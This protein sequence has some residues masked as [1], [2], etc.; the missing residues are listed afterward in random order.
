M[1]A[2]SLAWNVAGVELEGIH[3]TQIRRTGKGCLSYLVASGRDALVIDASLPPEIYLALSERRGARIRYVLDTHIHA[4]HLSR[5]RILAEKA[6]AE[7]LLP[8]QDR[9]SFP[10]RPIGSGEEIRFGQA[11]LESIRT[12]GHTLESTCYFIN[13]QAL[14][15]GDT[16]FTA[17]VGRPDLHA[18]SDEALE[19]ARLLYASLKQLLALGRDV[20]VFP[21]HTG[22]PVPFDSK[23][24]SAHISEITPR[25]Q[26]WLSSEDSFIKRILARIPPTPPNYGRITGLNEK[27]ELPEGDLTELE[28]GA[29]RG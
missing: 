20:V 9:V 25:L 10:Y 24:L 21:G 7:L 19:R 18:A 5:A 27:G 26:E 8:Q 16:L 13:G 4:D 22:E 6:N 15:T 12:P 2:W 14:F 17:G 29:N 3:I 11:L 23:T 1:R 28:A